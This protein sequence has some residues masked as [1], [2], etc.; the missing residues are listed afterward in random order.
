MSV[1]PIKLIQ[2]SHVSKQVLSGESKI[3]IL[4]DINLTI[5]QHDSVAIIGSSGSGKTTLLTLLAGLDT[6]TQGEIYLANQPLHSL[7]EEQ[8]AK[9]RAQMVGFIFQSFQLLPSLTAL[10]NVMLALEIKYVSDQTARVAATDWL[11]KVGLKDR[12]HHFPA[13]LSGGEQQRVAIARAFV[14]QPAIIFA[15]EMTGNLDTQ[16]GNSISDSLFSLNKDFGTTLVIVTHDEKFAAK[17]HR[18]F[19]LKEGVISSC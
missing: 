11:T 18:Q 10:E 8:R 1:D 15:D 3:T 19:L 17:C 5:H 7:T 12:L 9:L 4:S 6:P 2:V 16:T 14:T 13:K